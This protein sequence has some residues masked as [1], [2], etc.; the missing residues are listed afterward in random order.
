MQHIVGPM[1][2]VRPARVVREVGV[3]DMHGVGVQRRRADIAAHLVG[4]FAAPHHCAHLIALAHQLI[5]HMAPDV[6]GGSRD[7]DQTH[8]AN[9]FRRLWI[10]ISMAT[11]VA[12]VSRNGFSIMKSWMI[13]LTR[14]LVVGTPAAVSLRA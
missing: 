7:G 9:A 12:A 8:R 4:T 13:P 5:D 1:H 6:A 14:R 11:V 10:A 3:G 2:R